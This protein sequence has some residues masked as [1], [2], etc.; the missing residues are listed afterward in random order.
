MFN[1]PGA[2]S[3]QLLHYLDVH[4]KD[5]SINTVIIHI[6]INGLLTNSSRSGMDNL[7][8]NIK[9]ITEKRLMFGVK[10]VSISG[11]V[12]TT[13]VD[14]SL[15]ERIRLIFDF[16]RKNSFIYIDNR[17]IRVILYKKMGF[18]GLIK[19]KLFQQIILL[20]FFFRNTLTLFTK[21]FLRSDF[22]QAVELFQMGAELHLLQKDRR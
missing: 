6:G 2:S 7:I 19:G 9:K 12:C 14:V 1:F 13:R 17:N 16:C 20:N 8:L 4:L 10:S 5:K 18:I 22:R 11:L 21:K 3:H 15:L